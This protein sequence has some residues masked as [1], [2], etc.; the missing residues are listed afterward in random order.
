MKRC[1]LPFGKVLEKCKVYVKLKVFHIP[2]VY[3]DLGKI[4]RTEDIRSVLD[5]GAYKGGFS[6]RVLNLY[7]G[8]TVHAFEPN[9][10]AFNEL[11]ANMLGNSEFY[12]YNLAVSS[13][14]GTLNLNIN[15]NPATSSA[16][17]ESQHGRRYFAKF[18]ETIKC[19]E[20]EAVTLDQ[21]SESSLNKAVD[22]IK[23]DVQGLDLEVLKGAQRLL[24]TSV[25]AVLV[26][27]QFIKLYDECFNYYELFSFLE[28]RGYQL[29]QVYDLRSSSEG[30]LLWGDALFVR[31]E[32]IKN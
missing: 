25:K 5:V 26:E 23:V 21:W 4:F 27:V 16:L 6:R 20:V 12:V 24:E 8:A 28:E 31:P 10:E 17:L 19:M 7:R 32:F 22:F 9:P 18:L 29:F 13:H 3:H 14:T 30:R 15:R 11:K 1:K 2:D